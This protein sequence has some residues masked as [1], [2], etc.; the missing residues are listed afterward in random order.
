MGRNLYLYRV[1]RYPRRASRLC[2]SKGTAPL[3][4]CHTPAGSVL[5]EPMDTEEG[6]ADISV[7]DNPECKPVTLLPQPVADVL[8]AASGSAA[9][10]EL[11]SEVS[12]ITHLP[13][14]GGACFVVS[15]T[16][17]CRQCCVRRACWMV[18][19]V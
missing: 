2:H 15:P 16:A 1:S 9:D 8:A 10:I 6:T 5:M 7:A 3:G 4:G 11:T 12:T 19:T 13:S 18:A 14:P 17:Y